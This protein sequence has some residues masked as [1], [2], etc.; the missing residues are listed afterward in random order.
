MWLEKL[1]FGI[2]RVLTPMGPRYLRPTLLQRI[3]LLWIFRH[4]QMLPLQVLS[5]RQQKWIDAL[6]AQHRFVSLGHSAEDEPVLGT[7]EWRPRLE[8]NAA[9]SSGAGD[10]VHAS[11]ATM[12][13]RQ[14]S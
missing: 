8:Q 4:F 10:E 5:I 9:T 2:L 7:V 13:E 1:S 6:C 14:R 12:A 11:V 3:Y